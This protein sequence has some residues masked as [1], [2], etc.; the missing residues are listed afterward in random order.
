MSG[1]DNDGND[2]GS[3]S[4]TAWYCQHTWSKVRTIRRVGVMEIVK[5]CRKCQKIRVFVIEIDMKHRKSVAN[6]Y[7]YE[8]DNPYRAKDIGRS[9]SKPGVH[10]GGTP[11]T[12]SVSSEDSNLT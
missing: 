4:V 3:K 9:G 1:N 10:P 6:T 2:H 7:W 5:Q 11:S 12:E 8:P